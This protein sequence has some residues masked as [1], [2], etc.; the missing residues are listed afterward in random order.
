MS[1]VNFMKG[2]DLNRRFYSEVVAPLLQAIPHS[3][4]LVGWGSDVLGFDDS[5]STDHGWGPRLVVFVGDADVRAARASIDDGLPEQFDGW[6]VRFGWDATPVQ[7][8]VT[9]TALGPW[10]EGWLGH[11][12]RRSMTF[13]DWLVTPQQQLLGV[14]RGALY[15]DGLGEVAPLRAELRWFP[16]QLW[17]WMLACQWQR[18]AQEEAFVGRT[19]E[20]GD[21]LGSRLVAARLCRELMRLHFL[22]ARSY[23]PYTK[24]FGT[25]YRSVAG[26][27]ELVPVFA[28]ATEAPDIDARETALVRA[29]ETVA[30]LHNDAG[31]TAP[32]DPSVRNF[33]GRP[34]K[35][36][37]SERF[38]EA[39][40]ATVRDEWL[41]SLP[42]V[43]SIDQFV[44][45]TDVL[46]FADRARRLRDFYQAAT[47]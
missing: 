7:H 46:S 12:A 38:V 39:C 43:G 11:D 45:S 22:L 16:E 14:A 28:A 6:P 42:L 13:L 10:L 35:V 23:W 20:V 17:L 34:F 41:R 21:D 1:A 44:D 8:H 30:R 9:V 26:S 32:V 15:H 5:R 47:P 3:A 18:I 33:H 27:D 29:Y 4:G 36:L 19:A 40:L 2:A 31:I 37:A 25:A 24:W